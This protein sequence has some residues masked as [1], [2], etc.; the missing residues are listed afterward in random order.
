[1]N[2]TR[3]FAASLAWMLACAVP[4]A[5]A[6]INCTGFNDPIAFTPAQPTSTQITFARVNLGKLALSS[7]DARI[8]GNVITV[9][10]YGLPTS[11][12]GPSFVCDTVGFGPLPPGDYQLRHLRGGLAPGSGGAAAL[13]GTYPFTVTGGVP[14]SP[15]TAV[16]VGGLERT[17]DNLG[18]ANDTRHLA[19]DI[20]NVGTKDLRLGLAYPRGPATPVLTCSDGATAIRPG[21]GCTVQVP[22]SRVNLLPSDDTMGSGTA[23]I[24]L[25]ANG[26]ELVVPVKVAYSAVIPNVAGSTAPLD[27]GG[28]VIGGAPSTL[29]REF[30]NIGAGVA[31]FSLEI[32]IH[33]P[34]SCALD[35]VS[36][37]ACQALIDATAQSYSLASST[38]ANVP[39]Q[40]TCTASVTFDPKAAA[41]LEA[42][43]SASGGPYTNAV[44]V[45]VHGTGIPA[46]ADPD[47]VLAVEYRHA[48][49]D[50]YF[51][52]VLQEEI[53]AL[54]TG[55]LTGWARSGRSFWVYPADAPG[56]PSGATPVC[57]FYGRPEAGLDSHFYSA[58]PAECQDVAAR[59][60]ASWILESTSVFGVRLPDAAGRCPAGTSP[61]Y[62]VFNARKDANHRYT[63]DPA[64]RDSMVT[65]GGIAE[66]SGD[67]IV[68]MC[69]PQ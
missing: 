39:P 42:T 10:S 51:V 38:C 53:E 68:A 27:F 40:G 11:A 58:S 41:L 35:L 29:T 50:H 63:V 4:T 22:V 9:T 48:A 49:M 21:N 33:A 13:L 67:D 18:D 62:R 26:G 20:V 8:D 6:A 59:F 28:H 12:G 5:H 60:G 61:L 23:T 66:G 25:V 46:R 17:V 37:M 57:R 19:F 1:M 55:R 65:L 32:A 31:D 44:H 34:A 56:L 30:R 16:F 54:D 7:I 3:R 24:E 47:T 52:T 2:G 36:P 69:V 14:G 15:Y 43:L 64:V 45:K